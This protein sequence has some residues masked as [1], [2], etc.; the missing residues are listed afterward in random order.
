MR[1]PHPFGELLGK[2]RA[3]QPGLTQA[4]LAELCGY[5]RAVIVRMSQGQKDLTGTQARERVMRVIQVLDEAGV[6]NGVDEA[7]ALL[8][9]AAQPPL[10]AGNYIEAALTQQLALHQRATPEVDFNLPV[11]PRHNLPA[12]LTSFVGREQEIDEISRLLTETTPARLRA[13]TRSQ[14]RLVTLTGPGGVGKTRLALEVSA[15]LCPAYVDG[16]WWVPLAALR[17]PSLLAQS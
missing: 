2:L 1:N 13:R 5:D 10:F 4:R 14:A 3:R 15:T 8:Q 17:D 11:A 7:N 9:A 12:Q 16:V 6:L